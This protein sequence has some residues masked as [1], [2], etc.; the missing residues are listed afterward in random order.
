MRLEI[1]KLLED[2]RQA[3]LA[4]ERFVEGKSFGDY[5]GDELLR[6]AVERK[7][8]IIGEALGQLGKI[9]SATLQ[10]IT[11]YARII[12]FRNILIH[13]YSSLDDRIVW[14]VIAAHLPKLRS[15]CE[16]LLQEA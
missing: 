2:A 9:D 16:Q 8:E 15:E 12:A 3:A 11:H 6:A 14:D 10:R 5:A 1:K 13:G 7:F 4:I